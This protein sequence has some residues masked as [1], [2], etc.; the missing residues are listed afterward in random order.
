MTSTQAY[1]N[2]RTHPTH[3]NINLHYEDPN[4]GVV[5]CNR[6]HTTERTVS[7]KECAIAK[8][9]NIGDEAKER[10]TIP[11]KMQLSFKPNQTVKEQLKN[12]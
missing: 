11:E 12:S 8:L 6:V 4:R 9:W 1:E 2:K 3:C 7:R 5:E 10:T